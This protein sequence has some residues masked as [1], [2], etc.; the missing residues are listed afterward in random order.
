MSASLVGSEMCIRDSS[1]SVIHRNAGVINHPRVF[2]AC[3][4]AH[5]LYLPSIEQVFGQAHSA[6]PWRVSAPLNV[7]R[8]SGVEKE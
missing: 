3:H 1:T 6:E 7:Q 8:Q 5:Q 2:P 4:V